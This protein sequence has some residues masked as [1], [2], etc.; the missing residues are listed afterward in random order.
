MRRRCLR[1]NRLT[2]ASV[3]GATLARAGEPK[4]LAAISAGGVVG[5]LARYQAGLW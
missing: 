5:A 4:V 1:G 3:G 2:L